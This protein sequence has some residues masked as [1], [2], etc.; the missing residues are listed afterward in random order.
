[1]HKR[2][3]ESGDNV[4]M[5]KEVKSAGAIEENIYSWKKYIPIEFFLFTILVSFFLFINKEGI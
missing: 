1:M 4:E 5:W 3:N 2:E